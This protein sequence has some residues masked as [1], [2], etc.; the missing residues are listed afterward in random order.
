MKWE[1]PVFTVFLPGE[2]IAGVV[3][4]RKKTWMNATMLQPGT[5]AFCKKQDNITSAIELVV[6][7]LPSEMG[8]SVAPKYW[9]RVCMTSCGSITVVLVGGRGVFPGWKE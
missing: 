3:L 5:R 4:V 1:V 2:V 8:M 7:E 9:C 6:L